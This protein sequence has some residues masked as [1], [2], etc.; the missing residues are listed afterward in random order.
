MLHDTVEDCA[1]KVGEYIPG[2]HVYQPARK[3]QAHGGYGILARCAECA[4][5]KQCGENERAQRDKARADISKL[6][7]VEA[8]RV[9]HKQCHAEDCDKQHCRAR[10]PAQY[11]RGVGAVSRLGRADQRTLQQRQERLLFFRLCGFFGLPCRTWLALSAFFLFVGRSGFFCVHGG[12]IVFKVFSRHYC[13]P[14]GLPPPADGGLSVLCR[15]RQAVCDSH[16]DMLSSRR[17]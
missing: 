8:K 3:Q 9:A 13:P 11:H 5:G 6:R 4:E 12:N 2:R 14:F 17:G 16:Q 10:Y 15:L 7:L 1:V